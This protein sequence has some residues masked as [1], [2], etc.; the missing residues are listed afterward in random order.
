[1]SHSQEGLVDV[2]SSELR[3]HNH[4][5]FNFMLGN[6]KH[7]FHNLRQYYELLG[8]NPFDSIPLTYHITNGLEDTSYEAFK[9][10]FADR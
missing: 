3:V 1:M 5:E 10:C 6:K 2:K 4:L 9:N 7:F 8:K